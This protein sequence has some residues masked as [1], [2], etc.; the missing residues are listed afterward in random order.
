MNRYVCIH[1]HF[2]QPP[3]ENPW[4]EAI[5]L[6]DSAY[7]YHDWNERITAE[8]YAPN[9]ASRILD[10]DGQ[11]VEIVN[12]YAR[13]SFNFGPTL[14]G[15][16]ARAAPEIYR[17]ILDADV[18]SRKLFSGHGS[19]LAQ[20]YNHMI[21]P[22]ANRRDRVTQVLWGIRDF[23][24]RFARP[25]E[26][27]WLPETAVDLETLDILAELGIRFTILAAHQARRVRRLEEPEWQDVT[28]GRIDPK[29]T[30]RIVLPSGRKMSLFFYDDP[31]SR[32][33]AF[34]RLPVNGEHF[35]ERLVGAFSAERS[36]DQ[37]VHVATDGET[38]GH[39]V[40]RGEMGLAYA[41]RIVEARGLAQLT[42]Y[43]EYLEKH[44][45]ESEVEIFE[46]TSWSCAHGIE[47]WRS[48]CGCCSGG[49]PGWNQEWRGPLREA[50]DW[51]RDSLAPAFEKEAGKYLKDP[52]A[53]RDDY[54]A[55]V[56]DR[57]DASLD[58][59]FRRN[60]VGALDE[61]ERIDVL[62]LLEMQR[63]AMLMYTSCG[64]FFDELSGIETVQVMQ[65]AGRA[66]QLA[67]DVVGNSRESQ[68]LERLERAK[69]NL[70]E[71]QDGRHIYRKLVQTAM[72]DLEKVGAHYGISSLFEHYPER[73][74]VYCYSVEREDYHLIDIRRAQLAVGKARFTSEI[75]RE[76]A[77]L[78][79]GVLFFGSHNLNG[80]VREF[81]DEETYRTMLEELSQA[82]ST[83]DFPQVVRLLDRSFGTSTYSV[84][85]LFRDQQRNVIDRILASS[86]EGAEGHYR[87]I[88][89]HRVP[90][91]R[92]L[93]D[94]GMPVPHAFQAAA[95]FTIN[96]DLRR[97]FEAEEIEP[98][99][100]QNL[101]EEARAVKVTLDLTTLEYT[102]RRTIEAM[103]RRL[104]AD[105]GNLSLL[106]RIQVAV[107]LGSSL[108]F[109]VN[110]WSV[111]NIYYGMLQKVYPTLQARS[112]SDESFRELADR[113]RALGSQLGIRIAA[114]QS[115]DVA[116]APAPYG[117][118]LGSA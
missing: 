61:S 96:G 75:T 118:G 82:F 14:L 29:S 112:A 27:M 36:H 30:Y 68:F 19:A 73:T 103:V 3:R 40:W 56:L 44:P 39:H 99:Q 47:R 51:L 81:S 94:F 33:L 41:V 116:N 16:L 69:S 48:N 54:V 10:A 86:L 15:W 42:N 100:V 35:A 110:L 111:Q 31:I 4:L 5:E 32:A 2:Y 46:N 89:E 13:M 7:P 58:G 97:L 71:H 85:S 34:E 11:I 12:N 104:E 50:L 26:G 109:D 93:V 108:P 62:K 98:K 106:H 21:L 90:L 92:F 6:Q 9:T 23:E 88:Y 74:R 79:F 18:E 37:L 52:W 53:A 20:A 83:T 60:A 115:Q 22:L 65:Y 28:G 1:G 64:W 105:P 72:V 77:L 38:Y 117:S 95:E 113:F 102:L 87:Q 63:H 101:L 91:M 66:L 24:A 107:G 8:C 114:L 76:S 45:P 55:V 57:S 70:P 80:A 25:P 84:R 78:I 49:H 43:G 67:S 59:F 17:A